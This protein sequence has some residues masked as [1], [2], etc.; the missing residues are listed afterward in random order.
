M[1]PA[2]ENLVR[3]RKSPALGLPRRP[4]GGSGP[5]GNGRIGA[6]VLGGADARYA[7]NDST[8]WSG[9]PD[10]P[11]ALRDDRRGR[12]PA[13]LAE[14]RAALDADD[15]RRR[16]PPHGVRGTLLAGVPAVGDLHVR[17]TDAQP[18][19]PA[20]ISTSTT[21]CSSRRCAFPV[22]TPPV[23]SAPAQ[24]LVTDRGRRRV[25]GIRRAGLTSHTDGPVVRD[26]GMTRRRGPHRWSALHEADRC[27]RRCGTPTTRVTTP[28]P[29]HPSRGA[30]TAVSSGPPTVSP[31]TAPGAC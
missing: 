26:G 24:V 15:A 18:D 11:P 17:I 4:D 5:L 27:R 9:T 30:P 14:V 8:L 3:R 13:R 28:S 10:D 16:R 12:G 21:P 2:A 29:R 1:S 20:R 7:L 6:M 23:G 19:D 31:S 25:H 22:A